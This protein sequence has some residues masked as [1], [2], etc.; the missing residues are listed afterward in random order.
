MLG[1]QRC[2]GTVAKMTGVK[3][4]LCLCPKLPT[5]LHSVS[6]IVNDQIRMT[7]FLPCYFNVTKVQKDSGACL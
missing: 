6:G 3:A 2:S 5:G 7:S 4:P 1:E